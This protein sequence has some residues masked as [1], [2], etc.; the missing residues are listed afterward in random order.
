L[1]AIDQDV[2]LHAVFASEASFRAWYEQTLPRVYGYLLARTGGDVHLAEDLT[3]TT[4]LEAV[5]SRRRFAGG[6]SPITW[7]LAIARH[8]LVDYYRDSER[9]GRLHRSVREIE[10]QTSGAEWQATEQR[11]EVAQVLARLPA[12]QRAA[13]VLH[14]MDDL[15]VKDVAQLLGKSDKAV[16]SLLSRGRV[17]F[18]RLHQERAGGEELGHG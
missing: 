10:P 11:D 8:R 13:L 2:G 6:S 3:Q 12:M 7:L 14:Y 18:R 15:S 4:Y 17:E 1:L 9:R 5:R 16:E